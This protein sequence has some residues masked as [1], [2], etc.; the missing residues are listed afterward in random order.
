M[1]LEVRL[2][3]ARDRLAEVV[4][5]YHARDAE[6]ARDR[7]WEVRAPVLVYLAWVLV[8]HL[9][10]LE[11]GS[12]FAGMNLP[13]HEAGHLVFRPLGELPMIA[14]GTILQCLAPIAAGVYLRWKQDDAFGAAF[15]LGWFATNCF[16]AGTYAADARGMLNLPLVSFGGQSFGA[17]GGGD[18]TRLLGHFGLLER[19]QAISRAW[20]ALGTA[21][22]LLAL[23]YGAW[24]CWLIARVRQGPPPPPPAWV[25]GATPTP[26]AAAPA[27]GAR[28]AAAGDEGPGRPA[29]PAGPP[30]R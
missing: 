2:R 1:T 27:P 24:L 9:R 16:D 30:A 8:Q 20:R 22:M 7:S 29:D 17:D 5:R 23:A 6:W 25:R 15:C 18:W 12:W 11:Y 4:R 21:S 14:G 26:A 28:R 19:D 10:S 13:I 3:A